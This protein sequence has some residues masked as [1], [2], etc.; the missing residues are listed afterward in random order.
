[1][2]IIRHRIFTILFLLSNYRNGYLR[3]H[4]SEY[5]P[6]IPIFQTNHREHAE[7]NGEDLKVTKDGVIDTIYNGIPD[8]IYE[9][10]ILIVNYAYY[11]NPSGSTIV[12]AQFNDSS[13]PVFKY[14]QYGDPYNI[15]KYTTYR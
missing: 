1:M 14:P 15:A 11:V 9:E 12:F 7:V 13:V 2:N 5:C 8:W 6:L 10:E 3:L 4:I